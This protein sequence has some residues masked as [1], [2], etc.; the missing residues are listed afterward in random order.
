VE[1]KTAQ[2][3]KESASRS[4]EKQNGPLRDISEVKNTINSYILACVLY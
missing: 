2:E 1:E 3:K 4:T